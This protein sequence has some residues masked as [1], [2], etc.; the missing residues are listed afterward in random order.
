[1]KALSLSERENQLV[2]QKEVHANDRVNEHDQHEQNANVERGRQRDDQCVQEFAN[3]FGEL[4]R[5]QRLTYS[6]QANEPQEIGLNYVKL[7]VSFEWRVLL[8]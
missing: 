3:A 1:L 7:E 4:E 6:E 8:I 5:S 2:I